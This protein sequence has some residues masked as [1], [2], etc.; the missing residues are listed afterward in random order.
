[1]LE[2]VA[3]YLVIVYSIAIILILLPFR[4]R[5]ADGKKLPSV[6]VIIAARNEE[7]TIEETLKAVR[8]SAY[9]KNKIEIIIVDSSSDNTRKIARKYA[10]RIIIDKALRGKPHALNLAV[11]KAKGEILYFIDAD[12]VVNKNTIKLHV[13]SLSEKYPATV[14]IDI[15]WNKN[16][17]I[18]RAARLEM[19]LFNTAEIILERTVK[20]AMIKGSNFSIYKKTLRELGG[21]NDVLTEDLNLSFRLYKK[22][23]NVRY[24]NARCAEQAPDRLSWYINQ[25]ERWAGGGMDEIKGALRQLNAFEL[26]MLPAIIT[27]VMLPIATLVS[28]L[29]FIML[30]EY[31]FLAATITSVALLFLSAI[32]DLDNDDLLYFPATMF[33]LSFLMSISLARAMAKKVLGKRIR[34]YKTPKEKF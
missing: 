26:L 21:F 15:P 16:N 18:A 14:G 32:K 12:T 3:I 28:L 33:A 1:M 9:P 29:F 25:Q 23:M 31:V 10:D 20:S 7:N 24:V 19:A 27:V 4:N 11:K 6:S 13:N 5:D 17:I 30:Q 2:F 8:K 22:G 34:W